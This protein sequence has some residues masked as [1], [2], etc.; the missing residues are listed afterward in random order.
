MLINFLYRDVNCDLNYTNEF[1]N[2]DDG[3][4][5]DNLL[6]DIQDNEY[7]L[8]YANKLIYAKLLKLMIFYRDK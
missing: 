4:L 1:S 2:L 3:E 6:N 7:A 5:K 8:F